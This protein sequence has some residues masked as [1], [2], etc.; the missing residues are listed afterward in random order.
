M[1]KPLISVILPIYN[2][3]LYIEE[4]LKSLLNQS[5]GHE[6]LE[7]L[8]VNDC[9]TDRTGEI[10][11]RYAAQYP[12]FKAIHLPENTG[13]PGKPRNTA[14]KQATGEYLICLDP[15]DIIPEDGYET[16][17]RAAK[18]YGSD[19]VMGKMVSFNDDTGREFEH[20]TFKDHLLQKPHHNVTVQSAPFFLQVK[21]AVVL[22]LVKTKFVQEHDIL[23]IE[24]MK[25]GEDKYFDIQLFMNAKTFSYLP[26]V[27]YKYRVRAD[28][29]NRSMTQQDVV[30]TIENDVKAAKLIRPLMDDA[31]Y[32]Y[33]QINALRSLLW[34]MCDA[35]FNKLED[36][37]KLR[38]L[39]LFKEVI[40]THDEELVKKYFPLEAPFVSLVY[41]GF[42]TEA[43]EY[44]SM[45][46]SRRWW[47]KKGTALQAKYRKHTKIRKTFSWKI[48]KVVRKGNA[49]MK[50]LVKRRQIDESKHN[51]TSA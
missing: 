25:N 24:G 8:M 21:T 33:F 15:D 44:N 10:I 36:E 37:E 4:C 51:S 14:I 23:F 49:K 45:L 6:N 13:A 17:Y 50:Q 39:H 22:K 28:E 40:E 42:M 27:V 3:E 5:I 31:S 18:Q 41:K 12:H 19:F 47:Y 48:T 16:L 32:S 38:L 26:K 30:S 2:V 1:K 11:D 34:K 29:E 43:L 46:I 7:V 20:V 35:D 9:S